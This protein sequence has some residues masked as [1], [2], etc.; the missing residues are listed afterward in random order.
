MAVE[1]IGSSGRTGSLV[2][3]LAAPGVFAA[4]PKSFSNIRRMNVFSMLHV[5]NSKKALAIELAPGYPQVAVAFG[6]RI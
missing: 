1:G 4:L 6:D 5:S 3:L 2:R